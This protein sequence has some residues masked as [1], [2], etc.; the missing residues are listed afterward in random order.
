MNNIL[1]PTAALQK[2][3]ADHPR[4]LLLTG[5]GISASSGIPTYRDG[6]GRWLHATPIQHQDFLTSDASRRR[7]WARSALGWPQVREAQPNAAHHALAALQ[8]AGAVTR[9]VTQN[10]DQLHQ[11][12]GS[13]DVIDLHGRLDR[14]RCLQCGALE[15]REAIQAQLAASGAATLPGSIARPDGDAD[16]DAAAIARIRVPLCQH[17]GGLLKPDVVFFGDNVPRARVDSVMGALR[18]ADALMVVGSSLQV[19]SGFRFCREAQR[20]GKPIALVNPGVTR[21]DAIASLKVSQPADRVLPTL[22]P[23]L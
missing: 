16:V 13:S 15:S 3:F 5:A 8:A 17:C 12:A 20:Q 19:Y 2:F 7:Y 18:E 14:V 4:V 11:K 21:A 10:V 6:S 1:Q 23:E 22:L 9:V